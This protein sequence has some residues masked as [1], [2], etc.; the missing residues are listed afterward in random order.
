VS[1]YTECL[2]FCDGLS[3]K[4]T[5]IWPFRTK[6]EMDRCRDDCNKAGKYETQQVQFEEDFHRVGDLTVDID[7]D[8]S[9]S[10][11]WG[12]DAGSLFGGDTGG[13]YATTEQNLGPILFL[14][15]AAGGLYFVG[16]A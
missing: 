9:A 10:A 5:G 15:L 12:P 8:V 14:A 1:Y 2:H 13:E 7:A 4:R 3:E 11:T 16:R 6:S